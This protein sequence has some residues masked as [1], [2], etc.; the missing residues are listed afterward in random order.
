MADACYR[1]KMFYRDKKTIS[2]L[3]KQNQLEQQRHLKKHLIK[4]KN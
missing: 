4:I 1:E 3:S 2:R